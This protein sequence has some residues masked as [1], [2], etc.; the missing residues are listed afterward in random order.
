[1][2]ILYGAAA[3]FGGAVLAYLNYL[4]SKAFLRRPKGGLTLPTLLRQ[5]ISI[6]YL[7]AL[8]LLA[9]P[10]GWNP[11]ALLIGGALGVTIPS[12]ILTALMLRQ[13]QQKDSEK[14]DDNG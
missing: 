8:Y 1:M 6:G 5:T 11:W 14:R 13:P 3:F 9:E 2:D 4:I 12:L 10:L 7:A